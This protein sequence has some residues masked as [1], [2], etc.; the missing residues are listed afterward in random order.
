[1]APGFKYVSL[2]LSLS[3]S[4][5]LFSFLSFLSAVINPAANKALTARLVNLPRR[6][7]GRISER[8]KS[9]MPFT[10]AAK[11]KGWMGKHNG[12]KC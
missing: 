12:N 9:A 11:V 5:L 8:C 6:A 7:T 10:L 2:L 1:M 3:L 4:T